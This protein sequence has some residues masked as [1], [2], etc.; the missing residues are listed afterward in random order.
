MYSFDELKIVALRIDCCSY[1]KSKLQFADLIYE[2]ENV[3]LTQS[4]TEKLRDIDIVIELDDLEI[5][6]NKLN[7]LSKE[8]SEKE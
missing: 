6:M 4:K 3:N 2:D 7:I 5:K 1:M 8:F